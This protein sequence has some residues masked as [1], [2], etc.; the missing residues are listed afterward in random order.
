[1]NSRIYALS[2]FCIFHFSITLL[3]IVVY[4]VSIAKFNVSPRILFAFDVLNVAF[5]ILIM[6][7]SF[8]IKANNSIMLKPYYDFFSN[9]SCTDSFTFY[10]FELA[11]SPLLRINSFI[12]PIAVISIIEIVLLSIN[13]TYYF[14]TSDAPFKNEIKYT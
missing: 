4:K 11:Y 8:I 2:I 10:S 3:F 5:L 13:Y 14:C 9:K 6:I 7:S 1:M 12:T